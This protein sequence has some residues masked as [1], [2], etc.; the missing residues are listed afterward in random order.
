MSLIA[1]GVLLSGPVLNIRRTFLSSIVQAT[2]LWFRACAYK[3]LTIITVTYTPLTDSC[4]ILHTHRALVNAIGI[5]VIDVVLLLMMLIGLLRQ[6]SRN[7]IGICKLLYQ[8]V[9]LKTILRLCVGR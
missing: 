8:Q 5:L 6:A 4:T 3:D 7:S 1:V 9:T 2:V